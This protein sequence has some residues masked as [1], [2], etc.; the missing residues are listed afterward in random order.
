MPDKEEF[1]R[2]MGVSKR[3][4]GVMALDKVDF[5]LNRGEVH[6]LVGKN[7]AGKS[8]LIEIL[9]G[10]LRADEGEIVVNGSVYQYLT[11]SKSISLGIHTIHQENQLVEG[12]TVAENIFLGNL[13]VNRYNVFSL[14]SCVKE[15]D[16]LF[17]AL[18]VEI[19][20]EKKA[21]ELSPVE[22][23]VISIAKAFSE[24]VRILILD[25]P[26]ASLDQEVENKLFSLLRNLSKKGVG[27]IYISHNLDEIFT[28]GDR[29][30][31]LRDG[32]KISTRFIKEVDE[33]TIINEMIGSEKRL[34]R[35]Q[36]VP[37]TEDILEI[38]KYSRAGFVNHVSFTVRGGEIFGIGGMIG[39]GRTELARIIFGLDKKDSGQLLL[40][41]KDITPKSPSDAI[42][43]GIGLMTEDRKKDGLMMKRPIF[44][45][46]SL[47]RLLKEKI[48]ALKLRREQNM[49][50]GIAGQ[51]NIKTPTINQLVSDLSGGNQQKVIFAKWLLADSRIIIL[52]EPTLGIDI[53]AKT[54][55][56]GLMDKLL[57]EKKIIIM[58]SSDTPELVLMCSRIGVMRSGSMVKILEKEEASEE[59]VLTFAIGAKNGKPNSDAR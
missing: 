11:P 55:I 6:C 37:V 2:I 15:A 22:K 7:G 21:Y 53:G 23:K 42:K 45:N 10:A 12:L 58:I 52:D 13:K 47:V 20:P 30:T 3:Y 59:N 32:R 54:E 34:Y 4:P 35:K 18:D 16:R 56:Y 17:A 33:K 1:L 51:L 57:R 49:V 25:E 26:T 14:N 48:F 19:D 41:Q 43:K 27:A 9:A 44:E 50:S 5:D 28:L 39:S 46:I 29:V 8:T 31:V 36:T 24:N 38:K 40:N